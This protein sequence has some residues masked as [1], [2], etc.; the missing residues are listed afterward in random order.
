MYKLEVLPVA[1]QDMVEAVRYISENLANPIAANTLAEELFNAMESVAEFPY[2]NSAY[3]PIRPLQYE[4]RK[5]M[6]K[7][8]LILYWVDEQSKTVTIARV[9]YA[10]R[11]YGRHL[12]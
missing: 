10:K 12:M 9:V 2:A 1:K 3:S 6:V 8:Y 4:Y 7:N 11:D 5:L